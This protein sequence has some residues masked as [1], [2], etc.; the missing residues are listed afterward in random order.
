[1]SAAPAERTATVGSTIQVARSLGFTLGPAL[2]TAVWS[3]AGARAG[4]TLAAGAA[5]VAVPLL[6]LRGRRSAAGRE[7]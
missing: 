2:V 6:A 1:M 7:R 3:L 5:A 4:L